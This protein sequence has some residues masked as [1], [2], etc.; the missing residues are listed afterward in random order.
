MKGK[1]LKKNQLEFDL[2]NAGKMDL[3]YQA[4]YQNL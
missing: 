2:L 3:C 4:N 1:A